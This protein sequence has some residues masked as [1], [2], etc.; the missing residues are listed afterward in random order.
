VWGVTK[1]NE[2]IYR[3]RGCVGRLADSV[4]VSSFQG[5]REKKEELMRGGPMGRGEGRQTSYATKTASK[6]GGD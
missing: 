5:L 4:G 6:D 2:R 1:K 3:G